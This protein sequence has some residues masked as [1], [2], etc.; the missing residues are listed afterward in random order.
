MRSPSCPPPP[1]SDHHPLFHLPLCPPTSAD[2]AVTPLLHLLKATTELHLGAPMY[3][4]AAAI[5][6]DVRARS[7]HFVE[8]IGAAIRAI[9]LRRLAP[10]M[11][12]GAV[13]AAVAN[14]V[15]SPGDWVVRVVVVV[16]GR[17]GGEEA[18][19]VVYEEDED[20]FLEEL[21]HAGA[22]E[23]GELGEGWGRWVAGVVG[24]R[25]VDR[26]VV[27]GEGVG[28]RGFGGALREAGWG[29]ALVEEALGGVDAVFA[30]A[31]GMA[32]LS[33]EQRYGGF[34]EGVIGCGNIY[35]Y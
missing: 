15:G 8:D 30:S 7:E 11:P 25:G 9:G 33:F 19:V 20:G 14:G 26:V 31:M 16:E 1:P 28:A 23:L 21:G 35:E 2:V 22:G 6:H 4:V 10:G 24:G 12:S 5:Q 27:H 32:W 18:A 17:R 13:A 34:G 3:Y 29:E